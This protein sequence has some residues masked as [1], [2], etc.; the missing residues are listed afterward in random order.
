MKQ[1]IAHKHCALNVQASDYAIVHDN[2]LGATADV[3]GDAVTPEV[4]KAWSDVLMLVAT[5]LIEREKTLYDAAAARI[6]GWR[7]L[8]SFVV[9][10]VE[11]TAPR[12]KTIY[13]EPK[14]GKTAPEFTPGQYITVANNPTDEKYSAPRHYTLSH[15][16]K[17]RISVQHDVTPGKPPG[18][19]STFLHSRREGDTL[20]LFPPFGTFVDPALRPRSVFVTGGIGI[21][22]AVAMATDAL[23]KGKDVAMFHAEDHDVHPFNDDVRD[24]K[25]MHLG[26][27][28]IAT[29]VVDTLNKNNWPLDQCQY[30]ISGPIEM[31]RASYNH[32]KDKGVDMSTVSFEAFGPKPVLEK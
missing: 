28:C 18:L 15:N 5:N 3:L 19:M 17:L 10:R 16:D 22:P 27:R 31:M 12:I 26:D 1:L 7:G 24:A 21:T 11:D 29:E 4:A 32:L 2:F 25:I 20:E 30:F 14:D 8:R 23:Q 9:T 6:G 13:F